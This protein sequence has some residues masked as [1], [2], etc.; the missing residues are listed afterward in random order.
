MK[1]GNGPVA[2]YARY[3]EN[4]TFDLVV[5]ECAHF[6]AMQYLEPIRKNPPKK[7]FFNHYSWAFVE[8]C[9]HLRILLEGEVPVVLVTDNYE[10]T[11]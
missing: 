3:T 1:V 11:L 8:G 7:F 6:D 2:D 5:A 10:T 9:H 4:E